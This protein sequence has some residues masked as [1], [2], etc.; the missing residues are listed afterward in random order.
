MHFQKF[1]KS[2]LLSLVGII[3]LVLT[4]LGSSFSSTTWAISS[5]ANASSQS[6]SNNSSSSSSSQSINSRN[7]I[8]LDTSLNNDKTKDRINLVFYTNSSPDD[9]NLV[10]RVAVDALDVNNLIDSSSGNVWQFSFGVFGIEPYKSSLDKFNFWFYNLP[11]SSG[12]DSFDFEFQVRFTPEVFG[13][14]YAVPIS[15]TEFRPDISFENQRSNANLA[16]ISYNS[17]FSIKRYTPGAIRLFYYPGD[18]SDPFDPGVGYNGPVLSHELA[19]ALFAL[20]D[21]YREPGVNNGPRIF[22]NCADTLSEANRWWG[23]LVGQV[24]PFFYEFRTKFINDEVVRPDSYLRYQSDQLQILTYDYGS[25][26]SSLLSSN[27]SISSAQ[28]ILNSPRKP[29]NYKDMDIETKVFN[30]FKNKTG[31]SYAAGSGNYR[32][33]WVDVT[34]LNTIYDEEDYR[35]I[36]NPSQCLSHNPSNGYRPTIESLMTFNYPI[37][38]SVNSRQGDKVLSLFSGN[39]ILTPKQKNNPL[40]FNPTAL[41]I[42]DLE[43]PTCKIIVS[44]SDNRSF[45]CSFPVTRTGIIKNPSSSIR[46]AIFE[47]QYLQTNL[48]DITSNGPDFVDCSLAPD[49][50]NL[51]CNPIPLGSLPGNVNF[52]L[53]FFFNESGEIDP[54]Y[55]DYPYLPPVRISENFESFTF[56]LNEIPTDVEQ[57]SSSSAVSSLSQS[58]N[59]ISSQ[60]QSSNQPQPTSSSSTVSGSV[61]TSSNTNQANFIRLTSP[62]LIGFAINNQQPGTAQASG[63]NA[64]SLSSISSSSSASISNNNSNFQNPNSSLLTSISSQDQ[65]NTISQTVSQG[66]SSPQNNDIEASSSAIGGISGGVVAGIVVV[67]VAGA[68]AIYVWLIKRSYESWK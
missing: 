17:D 58:S 2:N 55:S 8:A 47:T 31:I 35:I 59:S 32:E 10:K 1:L 16:D 53:L 64:S 24:D 45:N 28:N 48:F 63:S 56:Q 67:V 4:V 52:S 34:D 60:S 57:A 54:I 41:S 27:S 14:D 23:D 46:L 12:F 21:E 11:V 37:F 6:N 36:N 3:F 30:S 15:L 22:P 7:L 61:N 5:P 9:M 18:S 66:N 65:S 29:F 62:E 39:N 25:N 19:H 40:E 51:G 50:T 68:S 44:I 20:G 43:V 13:L 49:L 33:V 38:G 42:F 26:S